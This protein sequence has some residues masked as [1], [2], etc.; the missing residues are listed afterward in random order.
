MQIL[1]L[2]LGLLISSPFIS[3]LAASLLG[4]P[5][6]WGDY[7]CILLTFFLIFIACVIIIRN[8]FKS[9]KIDV[10][11]RIFQNTFVILALTALLLFTGIWLFYLAYTADEGGEIGL[12]FGLLIISIGLTQS[13]YIF[14]FLKNKNNLEKNLQNQHIQNSKLRLLIIM[15]I[16]SLAVW[17]SFFLY[18]LIIKQ[19]INAYMFEHDPTILRSNPEDLKPTSSMYSI[20]N[21][22]VAIS[23]SECQSL[24]CIIATKENIPFGI[25]QFDSSDKIQASTTYEVFVCDPRCGNNTYLNDWNRKKCVSTKD[26]TL[27][28]NIPDNSCY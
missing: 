26:A 16:T 15:A 11:S 9:D 13:Y 27:T 1:P 10:I 7:F 21:V 4:V 19:A 12:L 5:A 17:G 14:N 23:T 3:L 6:I 20:P 22:S 24:S 2:G 25:V 28:L 8:L 18:E